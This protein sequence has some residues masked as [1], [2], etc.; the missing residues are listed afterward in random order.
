MFVAFYLQVIFN[1]GLILSI[2]VYIFYAYYNLYQI[3]ILLISL[4]RIVIC[5]KVASLILLI[6]YIEN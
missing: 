2:F 6:K 4:I 5:R 3:P 1:K